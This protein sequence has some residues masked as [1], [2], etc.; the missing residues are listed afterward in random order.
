MPVYEY[1]CESCGNVHQKIRHAEVRKN[2]SK[3]Q[4]GG[5]AKFVMSR[6][7]RFQRGSGWAS[8]MGGASMPGEVD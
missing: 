1:K 5:M 4:C 7:G 6:P 8:R 3:C 2:D